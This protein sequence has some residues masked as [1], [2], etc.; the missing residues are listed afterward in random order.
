MQTETK[1]KVNQQPLLN[2]DLPGYSFFSQPTLSNAGG[3]GFYIK[4]DLNF[5]VI[6]EL[7]TSTDD[8][9]ALRI[10]IHNS[11]SLNV[12]NVAYRHPNGNLDSFFEYLN[13]T[14]EKIDRGTKYCAILGDFN[15]DLLKFENHNPTN[16]FINIISS[17]CFQ[18]HILQPTRITDHSKTL[19]DNIFLNFTRAFHNQWK[20]NI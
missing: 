19:I 8:Y 5:T 10:E 12:L 18:P 4:N 13:S 7:S 2:I 11:Y 15:L 20:Y 1:I 17:F 16:E 6:S 9:E 14:T 3:V